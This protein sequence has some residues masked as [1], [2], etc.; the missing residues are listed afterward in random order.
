MDSYFFLKLIHI[1]SAVVIAGTGAG[2]AFFMFMANRTDNVAA[3]A[4]TARHVV[5][6]DW[7]FTAPAVAIQFITGWLLMLKLGY[8]FES[9][10]FLMVISLFIFIGICWIPVV[11]IQYKLKALATSSLDSGEIHPDFKR[12][13]RI[14]TALGIPAFACILIIFWLMVFKPLSV[15]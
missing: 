8:S 7:I 6:A 10:W 2:I 15:I 3:I 13:M 1:L 12:M 9:T 5:L 11:L 4:I 14:W